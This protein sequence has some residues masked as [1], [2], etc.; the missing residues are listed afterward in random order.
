M[1]NTGERIALRGGNWNNTRGAGLFYLNLWNHRRISNS[2]VGFSL[3]GLGVGAEYWGALSYSGWLLLGYPVRRCILPVLEQPSV[4]LEL[5]C[6]FSL[7]GRDERAEYWGVSANS[8]WPLA[9]HAGRWC[10]LPG[11]EQPSAVLGLACRFSLNDR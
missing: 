1:R 4:E 10:V 9:Q 11:S 3:G 5:E 2:N 7:I 6:R 8:R